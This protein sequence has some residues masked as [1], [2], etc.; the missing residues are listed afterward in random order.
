MK[1]ISII[2]MGGIGSRVLGSSIPKQYIKLNEKMIFI[3]C[4][5]K[6]YE[7]KNID[8]IVLVLENKY[9]EIVKNEV[10]K[11]NFDLKKILFVENGNSRNASLKNAIDFLKQKKIAS[12]NDIILSHDSVRIFVSNE[13]INKNIDS[14]KNNIDDVVSTC[15]K[16]SD[17]KF[18]Y[19]NN[20]FK[21]INRNFLYN[22]QTPQTAT[23]KTYLDV[24]NNK[25][26]NKY[27][28]N[29]DFCSLAHL[30]NKKINLVEGDFLNFKI[31]NDNDIDVAKK[32]LN[33]L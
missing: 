24:F 17:S 3:Y 25:F 23:F 8:L 14:I 28:L 6:F 32:F 5:K 4:L 15:I 12:N 27:F 33:F 20:K 16:T 9:F 10:K 11:N 2:L 7:N 30:M 19:K 26:K 21:I 1:C 22:T 18:F 29:N 13:I 31:T